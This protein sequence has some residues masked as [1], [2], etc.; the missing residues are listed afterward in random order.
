ME[1]A[2]GVRNRPCSFGAGVDAGE[3]EKRCRPT[4]RQQDKFA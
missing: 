2:T 3:D 4:G 1:F